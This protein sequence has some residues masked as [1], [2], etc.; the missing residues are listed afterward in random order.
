LNSHRLFAVSLR[1]PSPVLQLSKFCLLYEKI[2]LPFS[3]EFLTNLNP[4]NF[5]ITSIGQNKFIYFSKAETWVSG[6]FKK[7]FGGPTAIARKF[8]PI[9]D[10]F[11][12]III[13]AADW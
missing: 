6:K 4:L 5:E 8:R 9:A 3:Q 1:R 10:R 13:S 12:V 7:A 11:S 2:R